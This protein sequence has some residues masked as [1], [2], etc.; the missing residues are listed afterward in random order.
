MPHFSSAGVSQCFW[1][2]KMEHQK[3]SSLQFPWR[4]TAFAAMHSSLWILVHIS[5]VSNISGNADALQLFFTFFTEAWTFI[6]LTCTC[7]QPYYNIFLLPR[8]RTVPNCTSR[9]F[10]I[11]LFVPSSP[12]CTHPYDAPSK[13]L[14]GQQKREIT[15]VLKMQLQPI[16]QTSKTNDFQGLLSFFTM[17]FVKHFLHKDKL[18]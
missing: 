3:L 5:M 4:T 2:P 14:R 1:G 16:E 8:S 18:F 6:I 9:S 10:S 7:S 12:F 15:R 17:L 13:S 11:G